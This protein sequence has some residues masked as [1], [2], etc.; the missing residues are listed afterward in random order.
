MFFARILCSKRPTA[1]PGVSCAQAQLLPVP[2]P[3]CT[4]QVT[5][6]LRLSLGLKFSLKPL[7]NPAKAL[8][9]GST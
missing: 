9:F 1:A 8:L 2:E 3:V 6:E 4:T 7:C 5:T